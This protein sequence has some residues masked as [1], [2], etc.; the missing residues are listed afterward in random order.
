MNH[1]R[2][3]SFCPPEAAFAAADEAGFYLSIEP[4]MWCT[5]DPGSPMEAMLYAETERILKAYGN[6]PSFVLFSPSNEPK[7][8]WRDVLP[9][10]AEHFRA[11]DPRRLYTSG[12]GFT[13]P[14]APGPLD[15]VDFTAVQRFGGKQARGVS[16]W[17]G[18]DY[19]RAPA[20]RRNVAPP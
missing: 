8:H 15:K 18:G 14:D 12:T 3:H 7:G 1:M 11:A 9:Q 16:G 20:C 19:S 13:D 4:G 10:W 6:H 5:F 17:F 2:F